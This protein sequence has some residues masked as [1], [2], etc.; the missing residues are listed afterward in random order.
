VRVVHVSTHDVAGGAA[1]A[2]YRIHTSL[3]DL[4]VDSSMLVAVRGSEDPSVREIRIDRRL[5]ARVRRWRLRRR[6]A[7]DHRRLERTR[8]PGYERFS[9][10]R[11]ELGPDL[12]RDLP[13]ADVVHLH[14]VADLLDYSSFF[15]HVGGSLPLVWTLH[16]M[17]PFTGGCHY[18][19]GCGR[20]EDACG[21]CPQLGSSRSED[22]SREVWRRKERALATVPDRLLHVVAGSEWLRESVSSSSLFGRFAASS[23]D[24]GIDT[25]VFAPPERYGARAELGIPDDLP[26]VLFVADAVDNRRK[27]FSELVDALGA[28]PPDLPVL[29][30]SIGG[31]EPAVPPGLRHLHLGR[32]RGDAALVRVY[33][34]ADLF[35]IPSLQEAYGQTALEAMACGTP[36]VGFDTGGMRMLIRP[37]I[38]G[39]LVPTGDTVA[40]STAIEVLLRDPGRLAAMRVRCRDLAV[41]EHSLR[42]EAGRYLEIYQRLVEAGAVGANA[43][44]R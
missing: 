10:D 3:L 30:V 4:G 35:V 26:V 2:A 19:A 1:R 7:I 44:D 17:N 38:T 23:F 9:D 8:P 5:G 13:A 21:A 11:T 16:D 18:D 28:L 14:W 29:L 22:L 12:I 25:D 27:G 41:R 15:R 40:L 20:F 6:L 43:S 37:G 34:A 33:G 32:V 42:G 31:G 24:Y 36:A 39:E